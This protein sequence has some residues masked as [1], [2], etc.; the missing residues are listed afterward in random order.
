MAELTFKRY[1]KKYLLNDEQYK[2]LREKTAD[3]MTVDKYGE[4]TICNIYYDTEDDELIRTSI[5]KP[6]YKEKLRLRSYGVPKEDDTVFLEIKKKYDGIV[7]KRRE[8]ITCADAETLIRNGEMIK[9]DS[10]IFREIEYFLTVHKVVPKL[11]LAYDRIAMFGTEQPELRI[12]FDKNIRSRRDDLDLTA[13]DRGEMLFDDDMHLMELKAPGVIPLRLV[14]ILSEMEI[15][16]VSFSKYG[17]VY[18]KSLENQKHIYLLNSEKTILN[19]A[20]NY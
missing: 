18:K 10:Q 17:S 5:E 19:S 20:I 15:Y 9:Y 2:M 6:K 7:Y 13:G 12:T 8:Q 3:F 1:E 4:H 11:Y 14:R 16:P